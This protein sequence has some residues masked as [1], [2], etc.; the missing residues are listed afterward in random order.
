MIKARIFFLLCIICSGIFG[1]ESSYY[2]LEN[3]DSSYRKLKDSPLPPDKRKKLPPSALYKQS[4]PAREKKEIDYSRQEV[5]SNSQALMRFGIFP[6]QRKHFLTFGIN[7]GIDLFTLLDSTTSKK[8]INIDLLGKIGYLYQFN[9]NALRIYLDL[10]G[11]IPTNSAIPLALG[12]NGNM[13]FLINLI[14]LDFYI[15][16]GY[17]A[18]YFGKGTL[19]HGF[20]V[21]LGISK[22]FEN[23]QVEF[24]LNI[25]FYRFHNIGDKTLHHNI[26]FIISYNYKL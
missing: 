21:N 11:R 17:G 20:K 7:S 12:F 2:R 23:H 18:E 16:A 13:D 24:G 14:Y 25:P 4:R 26:D 5:I 3:H 1:A 22:S 9:A 8:Y 6:K 15:G 10:G 19:S